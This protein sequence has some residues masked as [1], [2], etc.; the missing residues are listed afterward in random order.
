MRFPCILIHGADV[1]GVVVAS[2]PAIRLQAL[3]R[4]IFS[5]LFEQDVIVVLLRFD[6][7]IIFPKFSHYQALQRGVLEDVVEPI[8]TT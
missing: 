1:H 8:L 6:V 7:F 5:A 4:G 3:S 2:F